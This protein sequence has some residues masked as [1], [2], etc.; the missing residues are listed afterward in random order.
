M[1]SYNLQAGTFFLKYLLN[2]VQVAYFEKVYFLFIPYKRATANYPTLLKGV[3][4]CSYPRLRTFHKAF[5]V[6]DLIEVTT[7][8]FHQKNADL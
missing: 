5:F 6:R 7:V 1:R 8:A 4:S 3:T 2:L